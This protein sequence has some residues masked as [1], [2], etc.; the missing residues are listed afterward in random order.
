MYCLMIPLTEDS[1]EFSPNQEANLRTEY[2]HLHMIPNHHSLLFCQFMWR[3][4]R[5]I[6]QIS[7]L[8]NMTINKTSNVL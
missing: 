2:D 3:Y 6:S 7:V 5:K 8:L 4:K 1:R